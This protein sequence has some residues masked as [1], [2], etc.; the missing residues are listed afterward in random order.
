M[1]LR[2]KVWG[3]M[4]VLMAGLVTGYAQDPPAAAPVTVSPAAAAVVS[5]AESGSTEDVQLAYVQA[6]QSPF[7]LSADDVIYL[8]DVGL[9]SAVITAMLN[10]DK[11]VPMAA[12]PPPQ[13]NAAP[14]VADVPPPVAAVD[15]APPAYVSDAPA[16]VS[17][18]YNSL[19]PY[20]AWVN[21]DGYGWCWQ[22]RTVVLNHGWRPYCDGGHWVYTDGGWFWQSD[23]SWGW[24]P[25]HYGRWVM[26]PRNG[27]CW[28]PDRTWG[29]AWVVW[30][31]GGDNCGWAPLPLHADFV[32][33]SGF[34]FNGVSV[35]VGFDFG[36]RADLFTF[37]GLR[38]FDGRELAHR[39]LAPTEVNRFYSKT[40]VI[41]NYTVNNKVIINH[42]I[43]VERVTAVTHKEIRPITIRTAPA[44]S[45]VRAS[46]TT[47]YRREVQ[48]PARPIQVQAQK[49]DDRHPVIQHTPVIA[50]SRVPARTVPTQTYTPNRPTKEVG[51][52]PARPIVEP[53]PT[54]T[55][56]YPTTTTHKPEVSP[57]IPLQR[58][59]PLNEPI[60]HPAQIPKPVERSFSPPVS[61]Q[62]PAAPLQSYT[63]PKPENPHVYNPK[64]YDQASS[65]HSL[66]P[67]NQPAA[68]PGPQS[69][70]QSPKASGNQPGQRPQH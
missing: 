38:D 70:A 5:M 17:Y 59:A 65:A 43:P 25:F 31:S 16:D 63:V 55:Q 33:G 34:R 8:R 22:P 47:V 46:A 2:V 23:Y 15:S 44:N 52:A 67:L 40:T 36:L 10:H 9:S 13:Y 4:A 21:L 7:N 54:R 42:G 39:R 45:N 32:V 19:Q 28:F 6:S 53:G 62:K 26:H 58:P 56:T 14:P 50:P 48:A 68:N 11:G 61:Y 30:R 29:P 12:Q 18:F 1:K 37:V 24:A 3:G 64:S 49:V 66:P 57:T 35:G 27:W 60:V 20:G 51:A 69:P 41:N